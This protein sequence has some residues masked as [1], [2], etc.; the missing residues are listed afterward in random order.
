M[1]PAAQL[2]FGRTVHARERPFER[3]FSHRVAMLEVDIDRMSEAARLSKLFSIGRGNAISFRET[4][5][6]A[7]NPSVPLRIW[8][9]A[10]LAEAGVRLEGG[11]LRLITFP[12]VLGYGFAP[13]SLWYGYGPDE[14]LRGVIYEV[15]NTFGETHAYVSA[16]SDDVRDMQET[17]APKEFHVSPFC[18]VSGSYRFTLTPPAA[19]IRDTMALVVE[20]VAADGREH[21]ATLRLKARALTSAAVLK[22]LAGMPISGFGVMAAIHWQA[23]RL[24]LKGARYRAKLPQEARR[25]T[26]AHR[27]APHTSGK[28]DLRKRA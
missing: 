14:R 5:Y 1:R 6:G 3:R 19:G 18:D 4:D 27:Q 20:N 17:W 12:R 28:E 2:W 23:L 11:A 9:E 26:L 10:R 22:W 16:Y 7:R 21:V 15:H 8:A 25:T 24:W 13:I